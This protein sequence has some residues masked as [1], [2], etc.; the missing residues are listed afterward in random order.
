MQFQMACYVQGMIMEMIT[1]PTVRTVTVRYFV[2]IS[3]EIIAINY[4]IVLLRPFTTNTINIHVHP[5]NNQ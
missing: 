3:P 4:D 1:D 2:E 5:L